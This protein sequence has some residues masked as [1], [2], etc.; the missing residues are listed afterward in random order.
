MRK[1]GSFEDMK[2]WLMAIALLAVILALFPNI[3]SPITGTFKN[4]KKYFPGSETPSETKLIEITPK[5]FSYDEK[6]RI[7]IKYELA[8][9]GLFS[10]TDVFIN[11]YD[12]N[13]HLKVSLSYEDKKPG[14]YTV[15][16]NGENSKDEEVS[17]G[18]YFIQLKAGDY[19]SDLNEG[20]IVKFD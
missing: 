19:T 16:W 13:G 12:L 3:A 4:I 2:G 5:S 10:K 20:K 1:R 7:N 15:T 17:A 11:I 14:T 18:I 8:K 6:Q 9:T